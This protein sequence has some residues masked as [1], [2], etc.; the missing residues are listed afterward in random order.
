MSRKHFKGATI[1]A[2][3][4]AIVGSNTMARLVSTQILMLVALGSVNL[5]AGASSAKHEAALSGPSFTPGSKF[6]ECAPCAEMIVVPGGTF[7]M[8]GKPAIDGRKDDDP[9]GNATKLAPRSVSISTFAAGVYDV[10]R[11][12]YAAFVA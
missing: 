3:S 9:T 1:T 2:R 7:T 4:K 6:Q 11:D 8:K 5:A 12:E 10:T